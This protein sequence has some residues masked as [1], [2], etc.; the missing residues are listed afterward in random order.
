MEE[1][2][3]DKISISVS[4]RFFFFFLSFVLSS[5]KEVPSL[6]FHATKHTWNTSSVNVSQEFVE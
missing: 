1:K 4:V 5:L 3:E 6:R 2:K